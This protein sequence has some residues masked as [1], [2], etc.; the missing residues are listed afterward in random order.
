MYIIYIIY[1]I[2]HLHLHVIVMFV[3]DILGSPVSQNWAIRWSVRPAFSGIT[4]KKIAFPSGL[5]WITKD[6]GTSAGIHHGAMDLSLSPTPKTK[7][8]LTTNN[9]WDSHRLALF[10]PPRMWKIT[11]HHPVLSNTSKIFEVTATLHVDSIFRVLQNKLF[12][13]FT[14]FW[15]PVQQMVQTYSWWLQCLDFCPNFWVRTLMREPDA[16]RKFHHSHARG[17]EIKLT[18]CH[19][20]RR[21]FFTETMQVLCHSWILPT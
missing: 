14:L 3:F 19:L 6:L 13:L 5:T 10:A 11:K 4:K 20:F 17:E 2:V 21:L 16:W 7:W 1:T 15:A 18:G 12:E 9:P 8:D